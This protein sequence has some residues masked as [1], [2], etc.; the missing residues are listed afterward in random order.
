[1]EENIEIVENNKKKNNKKLIINIVSIVLVAILAI[2]SALLVKKYVVTTFIVDGISMYPSLDG[3]NGSISEGSS[4]E[5]RTNGEVLYL[6][7]IAKIKR[8]D[9]VVF[10]PSWSG[11]QNV[12]DI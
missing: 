7:M 5:E 3:G 9:I 4:E 2:T 10:S 1:M 8:G 12:D 6:N 11:V